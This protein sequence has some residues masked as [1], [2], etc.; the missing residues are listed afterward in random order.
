[1]A[2][3]TIDE[4][5]HLFRR[6]GFGGSQAEVQELALK[7]REAAVD[8][9]LNF[10]QID[11]TSMDGL[12]QTSFDFSNP[13]DFTKFNRAEIQRWWFTRMVH[14]RRQFEEKMTL[15]WHNHFA[16]AASKVPEIFMFMQ[17]QT[18][19][20]RALDRFDSLL[21][22]I[23]KDPSHAYL[24]RRHHQRARQTERE[25]GSRASGALHYGDQGRRNGRVKLHR[26]RRPGD[27]TGVHRVEVLRPVP[28]RS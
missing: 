6:M 11:N 21:S 12:L 23:A 26:N 25:L 19:R 2:K 9:F 13:D 8:F 22:A 27:R 3:I 1:M 18:L 16:T 17:N 10:N 15:F 5:A 14:T 20:V 28:H 24:A 7:E 4:A